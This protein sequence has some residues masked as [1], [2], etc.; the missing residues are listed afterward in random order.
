MREFIYGNAF[1]PPLFAFGQPNIELVRESRREKREVQS[2]SINIIA[3]CLPTSWTPKV[4]YVQP[5]LWFMMEI[6]HVAVES[7]LHA[8]NKQISHKMSSTDYG[9]IF[10]LF[11]KRKKSH[12]LSASSR[13]VSCFLGAHLE[14]QTER[15]K[16]L[17]ISPW[18]LGLHSMTYHRTRD[19]CIH[20]IPI[21]SQWI[22]SDA[23]CGHAKMC[24]ESVDDQII[25]QFHLI[26][27]RKDLS[28]LFEGAGKPFL[29]V[30]ASPLHWKLFCLL[31]LLFF[32]GH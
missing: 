22:N 26:W 32:L 17:F 6:S 3:C 4:Y 11:T 30:S 9:G 25:K 21:N 5:G 18:T 27:P 10:V 23:D 7:A 8:Q 14:S 24:V 19:V 16:S 28:I 1:A 29:C 12:R 31:Q 15:E 13:C 20:F 2:L